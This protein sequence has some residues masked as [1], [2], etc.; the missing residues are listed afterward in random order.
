MK[1]TAT[2]ST[3]GYSEIVNGKLMPKTFKKNISMEVELNNTN[4]LTR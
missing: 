1:Y 4:E 2:K 3:W